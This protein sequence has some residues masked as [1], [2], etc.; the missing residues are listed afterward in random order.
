MLRLPNVEVA[1]ARSEASP[2]SGGR[3]TASPFQGVWATWASSLNTP[4][5]LGVGGF[6]YFFKG[7][8]V[9]E[10]LRDVGDRW[11]TLGLTTVI[12]P[13]DLDGKSLCLVGLE[14][15]APCPVSTEAPRQ[16][17]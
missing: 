9:A 3:V 13:Y 12:Y 17:R 2:W 16:G 10:E 15:T 6:S 7:P 14:K 1:C 8:K 5:L 11:A 4:L